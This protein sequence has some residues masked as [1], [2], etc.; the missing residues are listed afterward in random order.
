VVLG[1]EQDG[2]MVETPVCLTDVSLHGCQAKSRSCPVSKLGDFIWFK[3]PGCTCSDWIE[4][5]LIEARKAFLGHWSIR[6]QFL[7][8][9]PYSVFKYLV[10]GPEPVRETKRTT[11]EHETDT[12]W[13]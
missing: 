6:I 10:Y 2:A 4:G 12:L 3:V 5:M 13:R 9:L 11:P 7:S 8:P 1:R